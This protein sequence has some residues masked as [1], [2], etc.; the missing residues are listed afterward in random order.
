MLQDIAY[1]A[2]VT[3]QEY[4]YYCGTY[5]GGK[6]FLTR[7]RPQQLQTQ[8]AVEWS[9]NHILYGI[10]PSLLNVTLFFFSF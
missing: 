3:Y 6:E 7:P 2:Q 1:G 9:S 4:I 10:M 8:A 5:L